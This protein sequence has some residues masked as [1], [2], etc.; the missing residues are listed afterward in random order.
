MEHAVF[1]KNRE[2]LLNQEVAQAFFARVLAQPK[3]Y[4]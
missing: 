4:L 1:S 2:L 3:P